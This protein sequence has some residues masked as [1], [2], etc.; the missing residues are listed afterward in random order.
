M[1]FRSRS[2][3]VQSAVLSLKT[4]E[5]HL[6]FIDPNYTQSPINFPALSPLD[7]VH[8]SNNGSDRAGHDLV[9]VLCC[10]HTCERL[11]QAAWDTVLKETPKTLLTS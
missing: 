11:T 8:T 6:T 9:K 5:Q 3:R 2:S 7:D 4:F 1:R 10:P